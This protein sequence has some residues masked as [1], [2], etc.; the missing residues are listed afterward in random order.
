MKLIIVILFTMV[1]I[2]C[3]NEEQESDCQ[4]RIE[5]LDSHYQEELDTGIEML[6]TSQK[7]WLKSDSLL[8]SLYESTLNL[9]LINKDSIS[10]DYSTFKLE[11][12]I[13]QDSL[14]RKGTE[15]MNQTGI[16]PELEEMIMYS[17]L[18]TLNTKKAEQFCEL[19]KKL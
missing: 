17:K 11:R 15:V 2:L 8:K 18:I 12:S 19:L 1:T 14:W 7:Y 5:S 10:R 6:K 3:T 13:V 4:K 9:D 16:F